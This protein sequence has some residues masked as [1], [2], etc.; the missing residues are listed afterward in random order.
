MNSR[1]KALPAWK[2]ERAELNTIISELGEINTGLMLLRTRHQELVSYFKEMRKNADQQQEINHELESLLGEITINTRAEIQGAFNQI[3]LQ[4]ESLEEMWSDWEAKKDELE[5]IRKKES[6]YHSLKI[7]L[8][9]RFI[10]AIQ[11][12]T[13][14]DIKSRFNNKW[15]YHGTFGDGIIMQLHDKLINQRRRKVIKLLK[16]A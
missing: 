8:S 14:D 13:P 16:Q 4:Y 3:R 10:Q 12:E 11:L 1:V 15:L 9:N 7:D 2:Q 6:E 5:V